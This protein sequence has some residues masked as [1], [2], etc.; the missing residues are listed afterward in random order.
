MSQNR[1]ATRA[2]AIHVNITKDWLNFDT[3]H[4][5][6]KSV[7]LI[8]IDRRTFALTIYS[9][10]PTGLAALSSPSISDDERTHL[11]K[12]LTSGPYNWI[13][14]KDNDERK[15]DRLV[16]PAYVHLIRSDTPPIGFPNAWLVSTQLSDGAMFSLGYAVDD[17][18]KQTLQ[19]IAGF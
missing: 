1:A 9:L 12:L 13:A 15:N 16:N 10:G 2:L 3:Y 8:Q 5:E 19:Q 4:I 7:A 11:T 14:L 6:L 17:Q 18:A